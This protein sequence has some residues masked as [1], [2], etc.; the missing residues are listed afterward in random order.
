MFRNLTIRDIS[1]LVD[2]HLSSWLT[3]EEARQELIDK[4]IG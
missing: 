4:A 2:R 1:M 3:I